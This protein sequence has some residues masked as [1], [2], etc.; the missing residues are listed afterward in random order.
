MVREVTEAE[1]LG[2]H[3]TSRGVRTDEVEESEG[4]GVVADEQEV[5]PEVGGPEERV[6]RP[7][8]GVAQ[9]RGEYRVGRSRSVA[10]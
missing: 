10:P 8:L 9:G 1:G 5:A 7:H 3:I 2:K 4:F 6:D